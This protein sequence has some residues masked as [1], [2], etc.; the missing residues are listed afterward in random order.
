M[1]KAI[2]Y[3]AVSGVTALISVLWYVLDRG[4]PA[5]LTCVASVLSSAI[6][7]PILLRK[8]F[9]FVGIPG[10]VEIFFALAGL[11]AAIYGGLKRNEYWFWAAVIVQTLPS[12]R[13]SLVS[14]KAYQRPKS[15]KMS[16]GACL[17]ALFGLNI[18]LR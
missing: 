3:T 13:I 9:Q 2:V 11:A 18:F 15:L 10:P 4:N 5:L 7:S 14:L 1:G 16:V 6:A 12:I 17:A 8:D